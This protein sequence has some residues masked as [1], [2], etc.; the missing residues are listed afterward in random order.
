MKINVLVFP[1]GSQPALDINFSLRESMRI[2]V[3]G[4]SSVED[5]GKFVYKNYIGNVPTIFEPNFIYEFNILL[6][7]NN[8]QYIIPTHDTVALYLMEHQELINATIV[9]SDLE[10]TRICRYKSLTYQKFK[11]HNFIPYIYD[12]NSINEFPVFLKPDSGQGGKGTHL[13]NNHEEL[14]Y[15]LNLYQDLLICEY[16]PGEE[17]TVDCFTDRKST[18]RLISPRTRNRVF[19]GISVHSKLIETTNEI[20]K[21]ADIL[22]QKLNF[23]GYWY[24]QLKKDRN[25]YYKLLEISTR[26]AG[27]FSLSLNRDIN[28]PLL[29]LL[30]FMEFDIDISPNDYS[31]ELDRSFINRYHVDIEYERV[32]VD[33]DDTLI[34]RN[35]YCNVYLLMYLFQCLNK[36]KEIIL[37]TRHS[38]NVQD[39]LQHYK[40]NPSMFTQIIQLSI[41]NSKSQFIKTDKKS[42]F[43]DNSFAERKE[44][45]EKLHIPTFDINNIEC[46]IDW[47]G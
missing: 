19:G 22:N 12:V 46:L 27:T 25:G 30:D 13:V 37:I 47:R 7:N 41:S 34:L 44:V 10:T 21:I 42:I 18:L 29:S 3:Y 16:L 31:I 36:K 11:H 9:S 4:A 45:K 39:T 2:E 1:C 5:H 32:Y 24:F 15:Q 38:G 20:K 14:Q 6:S 33:L 28:L 26:M 43:I 35:Q 23:R 40:I 17:I 8:I